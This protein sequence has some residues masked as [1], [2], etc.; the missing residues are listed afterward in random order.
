[1]YCEQKSE[2]GLFAS[3]EQYY[4]NFGNIDKAAEDVHVHRNTL[5]YRL[6]RIQDLYGLDYKD[7]SIMRKMYT[8]FELIAC[9][10]GREGL[11]MS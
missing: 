2:N 6:K 4:L 10:D 7:T 5:L 9:S 1:M 3:L 8:A 11:W